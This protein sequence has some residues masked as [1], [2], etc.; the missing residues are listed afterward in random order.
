MNEQIDQ[1][2]HVFNINQIKN[3]YCDI[4][5]VHVKITLKYIE[6]NENKVIVSFFVILTFLFIFLLFFILLD[7]F[8]F[9]KKMTF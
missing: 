3:S 1:M 2:R 7:N 6:A 9:T 4:T 8:I 5:L